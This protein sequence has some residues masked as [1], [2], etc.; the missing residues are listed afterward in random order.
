MIISDVWAPVLDVVP[1]GFLFNPD[2]TIWAEYF[3]R[4]T[5]HIL[6][7]NLT[8][9]FKLASPAETIQDLIQYKPGY[10][11]PI[12]DLYIQK[13]DELPPPLPWPKLF[14]P[15]DEAGVLEV[16]SSEKKWVWLNS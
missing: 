1:D 4:V 14:Y 15:D 11:F 10:K 8:A 3:F 16:P 9:I 2:N 5:S 7:H 13:G 6:A 12:K